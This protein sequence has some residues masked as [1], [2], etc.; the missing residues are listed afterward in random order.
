[1]TRSKAEQK[2]RKLRICESTQL[3]EKKFIALIQADGQRYLIGATSNSITLLA[4]LPQQ[5]EF[6]SFLPKDTP[7]KVQER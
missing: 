4:E 7:L 6:R 5:E 3:G 1:M 2:S